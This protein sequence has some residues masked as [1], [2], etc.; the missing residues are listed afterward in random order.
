VRDGVS[1]DV[2]RDT[3]AAVLLALLA[4]VALGVAAA[5]LDSAVSVGGGGFGGAGDGGGPSGEGDDAGLSS[6]PS[7]GGIISL[8]LV[9]YEFLREPPALLAFAAVLL[10]LSAFFYRDTGSALATGVVVG[11]LGTP[12]AMLG[13]LLS[14]CRPVEE[15]FQFDLGFAITG[16]RGFLPEGGG[17]GLGSGDGAASTPELLFALVVVAALVGSVIV[18]LSAGGDDEPDPG[19]AET[20]SDEEPPEDPD[21]RAVGRVAGAVGAPVFQGGSAGVGQLVG[22]SAG[23]LWSYP[24]AAA[25]IGAIVHRG[26]TLRDLDG[27]GVP[28]LVGAMTVGTAIIYAVG[29]T[30]LAVVLSLGP[31]EAVTVGAAAFLPAEA[32]KI[33]AAG[34]R[35]HVAE[36]G[37]AT[38][39]GLVSDPDQFVLRAAAVE[40]VV[41]REGRAERRGSGDAEPGTDRDIGLD[42]DVDVAPVQVREHVLDRADRPLLAVD[43]SGTGVGG[44]SHLVSRRHA[45]R[46]PVCEG[47]AGSARS[48]GRGTLGRVRAEE[49]RD[50]AGNERGR[51][52]PTH[53]RPDDRASINGCYPRRGER[54][55]RRR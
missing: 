55:H 3:L 20:G 43:R 22:Q 6:T 13:W 38:H 50:V 16:E 10:V 15:G 27:V 30:G 9:C 36:A 33:A 14:A 51:P 40:R 12:V 8:P 11:A 21:L 54:R 32:L 44:G 24:V 7:G 37:P 2:N 35:D 31:V 29:V 5:T 41:G 18:L 47:E 45:D 42:R 19:E 17:G 23:Y 4:V 49:G 52:L 48:G 34:L 25:A 53:G 46:H 1:T 39:L 28:T 26:T